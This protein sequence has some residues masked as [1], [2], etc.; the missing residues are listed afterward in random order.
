M[1]SAYQWGAV[2]F[3]LGSAEVGEPGVGVFAGV[4][5]GLGDLA[6]F[7][8]E[9]LG[10]PAEDVEGLVG[11]DALAF[12]EDPL[13][14]ADDV[15]GG[16]RGVQVRGSL[17]VVFVGLGGGDGEGGE[18]SE[19]KSFGPVDDPER[20]GVAGVEVESAG[21]VEGAGGE[22]GDR[23]DAAYTPGGGFGSEEGPAVV[24]CEVV[25]V[26]GQVL[27]DG[28]DAGTFVAVVLERVEG[29]GDGVGGAT[30]VELSLLI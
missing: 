16:Q 21:G 22:Q 20:L 3:G 2:S 26:E 30:P 25:G 13:G 11:G 6:E 29:G 28:V 27:G 23:Q 5:E 17:L 12:D 8:V 18:R 1:P 9:V 4:D 14:L 7:E 15:A 10:G 19:E 24:A